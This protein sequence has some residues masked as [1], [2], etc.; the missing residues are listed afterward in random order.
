MKLAF[1]GGTFN[2]PHNGHK[3]IIN[4]CARMFDKL[5]VFPN[6][7]SPD[8]N[9][10]TL[11]SSRHRINMLKM[12]IDKN[13]VFIDDFELQSDEISYTYYTLKY[14]LDNYKDYEITMIVGK[15]QLLNLTNWYKS[16]YILK[17]V[18]VL[19]Y[20][21]SINHNLKIFKLNNMDLKEFDF[22]YSSTYIRESIKNN[23]ILDQ[24]VISNSMIEYINK[25]NLYR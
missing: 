17:N 14:L 23:Q 25:N 8:N 15:D 24:D 9:K 13:N 7:I 19:C 6:N 18:N 1:Y 20:N 11:I 4:Q 3:M 16:D 12:I 10:N 21:R 5:L 22:P 2:P